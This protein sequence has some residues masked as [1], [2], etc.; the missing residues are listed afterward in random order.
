MMMMMKAV[1]RSACL[2]PVCLAYFDPSL[3]GHLLVI[4]SSS[5]ACG[6]VRVSGRGRGEVALIIMAGPRS[7]SSGRRA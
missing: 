5:M 4:A 2:R 3:T 7:I 6:A 1:A